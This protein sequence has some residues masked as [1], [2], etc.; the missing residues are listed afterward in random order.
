[1]TK[2]SSL[3]KMF[4]H[5]NIETTHGN[6]LEFVLDE[7][8]ERS[9]TDYYEKL[10]NMLNRAFADFPAVCDE[11]SAY[12]DVWM[13]VCCYEPENIGVISD[14]VEKTCLAWKNKYN[15]DNMVDI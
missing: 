4:V 11:W 13:V 6:R 9:G 10:F 1:M 14:I 3:D 7:A 8:R 15:V 5:Y 2:A 12:G